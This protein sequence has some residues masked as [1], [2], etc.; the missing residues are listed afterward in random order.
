[1]ENKCK[2]CKR[3]PIPPKEGC[4]CDF[5]KAELNNLSHCPES[6]GGH[7]TASVIIFPDNIIAQG[8]V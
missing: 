8:G 4:F 7:G 3:G 6:K 5:G 1:M 2:Q